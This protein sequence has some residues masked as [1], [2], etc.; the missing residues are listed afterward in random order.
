MNVE[1]HYGRIRPLNSLI[2]I[3]LILHCAKHIYPLELEG[4]TYIEEC[5]IALAHPIGA[6]V[7]LTGGGR[8]SGIEYRGSRGHFITFKQD[9]SQLLTILPSSALDLHKYVTISWAG[10]VYPTV[11]RP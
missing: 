3:S 6:I 11:L 5:V 2:T 7:K 1:F 9:L 10:S 8:S 4:L